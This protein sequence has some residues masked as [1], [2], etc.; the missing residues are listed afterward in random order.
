MSIEDFYRKLW[1]LG[2]A[3]IDVRL[4]VLRGADLLDI[5]V[6]SGDRYRWLR[7]NPM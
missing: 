6:H 5:T 7:L 1:A 3:G 2:D 4:T